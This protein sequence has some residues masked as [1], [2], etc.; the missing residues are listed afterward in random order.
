MKSGLRII[1][2]T[3][4]LLVSMLCVTQSPG[5]S[6]T[7]YA[8][9]HTP[10]AVFGG[11]EDGTPR[12]DQPEVVIEA[13][14]S[15]KVGD[16]IVVDLSNSIGGGFDL[17]IIPEPPQVRVFNDGKVI[18]TASGY[19]TTEYLFIA[20]CALNGQSDVKTHRVRVIGPEPAKP[21]DPGENLV[22]KVLSWCETVDSPTP[23]D[24]A[25]KLAQSFSSL[26]TVIN[27]G[28]FN[29]AAE[30]VSATKTSNRDA[31][32]SNLKYWVPLLDGLMNELRAM[33]DVGMLPDPMAHGP[34]WDAVSEGLKEYA[35]Q[36]T[37]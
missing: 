17:V 24:D 23:R 10:A 18:V 22:E 5:I 13:P 3:S 29:T 35:K 4:L 32:G 8:K 31:L 20:S 12:L 25:L 33:S 2:Y 16:M 21:S 9:A 19:E 14:S 28:T 15:V 34:V 26:A 37:E 7:E 6:A 30:I 27:N 36:L 1:A 11:E